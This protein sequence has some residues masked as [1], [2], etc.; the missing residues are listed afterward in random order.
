MQGKGQNTTHCRDKQMSPLT[1]PEPKYITKSESRSVALCERDSA[2]Y[3]G[4]RLALTIHCL[5]CDS[6]KSRVYRADPKYI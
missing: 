5:H 2:L 4:R 6:L 3:C 1:E